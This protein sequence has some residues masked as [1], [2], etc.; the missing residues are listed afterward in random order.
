MGWQI[1]GGSIA[2]GASASWWFAWDR[3]PGNQQIVARPVP[4]SSGGL[5]I[6]AVGA[7]L[8]TSPVTVEI[9]SF[10]LGSG[11][12]AYTYHVTVRNVGIVG[13]AFQWEGQQ[14]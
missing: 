12:P 5:S 8:E 4:V 11:Q 2:G 3:W 10:D 1:N 13:T 6:I 14:V 9:G 7:K